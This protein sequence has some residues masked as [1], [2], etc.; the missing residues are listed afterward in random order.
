MATV[1]DVLTTFTNLSMD[2]VNA[3]IAIGALAV[4]AFAIFAVLAV[5]R[6]NRR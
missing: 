1:S 5:V 2:R 3:L 6:E 4:A